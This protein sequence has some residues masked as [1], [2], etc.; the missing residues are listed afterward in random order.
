V[1]L[2]VTH[3]EAQNVTAG[4]QTYSRSE[5]RAG[6]A[7]SVGSFVVL[8]GLEGGTTPR[9]RCPLGTPSRL[10]ARAGSPASLT[11]R[12]SAANTPSGRLEAQYRLK[13]AIPVFG[14]SFIGG[15]AAEAGKMNKRITEVSLSGWQ[16]SFGAY[17]AA[18]T[19]LGPI[20]I[21]VADARN[22]KARFYL[23]IGTP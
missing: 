9:A 17:L 5:A 7:W 8:G 14:L 21:G 3:F 10:A 4:L 19:A 13:V 6:G 18:S 16:R 20:Y 1:K 12:C 22:G 15:V 11:T 2:D 23:F